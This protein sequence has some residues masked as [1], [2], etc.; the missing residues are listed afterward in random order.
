MPAAI[1]AH[2]RPARQPHHG[3]RDRH[4]RRPGRA[5]SQ[6]STFDGGTATLLINGAGAQTFTGA[7]TTASGD[8]P[9]LVINKPSGTLTLAGTIRTDPQLDV[10]RGD[11]RPGHLDASSSRA[12]RSRGSHTL[13]D[14][15]VQRRDRPP[16]AAGTTLDRHRAPSA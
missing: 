15:D 7:A 1:V 5:S 10:H 12:A 4:A 11:A 6:A 16:P 9:L 3:T 14:V 8:L 13:N 2:R